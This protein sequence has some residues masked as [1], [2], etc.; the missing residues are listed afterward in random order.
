MIEVVYIQFY[1]TLLLQIFQIKTS[2]VQKEKMKASNNH[3]SPFFAARIYHRQSSIETFASMLYLAVL[4]VS[5]A[6]ANAAE[7]LLQVQVVTRHG[8]RTPLSKD[9]AS[10][11]EG[12]SELTPVGQKIMYDL[13]D[14]MRTRYANMGLIKEYNSTFGTFESSHLDRTVVSASSFALGLYPLSARDP[15]SE[16]LLGNGIIPANVPVYMRDWENDV[17][18]RAYDKCPTFSTKLETLY[19]SSNW[20]A[21]QNAHSTLL[22]KLGNTFTAYV[23]SSTGEVPLKNIW[24]CFDAINVAKTECEPDATKKACVE[25]PDPAVRDLLSSNEWTELKTIAH[26]AE[27]TKYSKDNSGDLLGGNL[28]KHIAG[29]MT[30]HTRHHHEQGKGLLQKFY[31]Y[32]GHYPTLLGLFSALGEA[33]ETFETIPNYGTAMIFELWKD[34]TTDDK[35]VKIWYKEGMQSNVVLLKLDGACGGADKCSLANFKTMADS[36]SFSHSAGWCKACGNTRA[37]QCLEAAIAD[38]PSVTPSSSD[39]END[40][41]NTCSGLGAGMFFAGALTT[42]ILFALY[43]YVENKGW[44]QKKSWQEGGQLQTED[45]STIDKT[46]G[47]SSQL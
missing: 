31:M 23:D 44:C 21:Y 3:F 4:L 32:S 20:L 11:V 37:N 7:Q 41:E 46:A 26:Y 34:D 38:L 30:G 24:N 8:A 1:S 10:L 18:I 36:L 22:K 16:S 13:G 40:K 25:L 47:L 45:E 9:S 2:P 35:T 42:P 43:R 12:G 5:Y 27:L 19:K 39:S 6:I 28:F 15:N 17:T 29:R 14:F 33:Y